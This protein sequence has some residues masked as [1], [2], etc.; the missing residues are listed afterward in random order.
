MPLINND[1]VYERRNYYS[2]YHTYNYNNKFKTFL[3]KN[4]EKKYND[5]GMLGN[6]FEYT[7]RSK[8]IK[9]VDPYHSDENDIKIDVIYVNMEYNQEFT[10]LISNI[11]D[12]D[13]CKNTFYTYD[14]K[15]DKPDT[16]IDKYCWYDNKC[17]INMCNFNGII[18]KE[19]NMKFTSSYLGTIYRYHKYIDRGYKINDISSIITGYN[20]TKEVLEIFLQGLEYTISNP[21]KYQFTHSLS[22]YDNDY[23]NYI[24]NNLKSKYHCKS[25]YN[26]HISKEHGLI[27]GKDF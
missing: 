21:L 19:I 24:I 16:K 11:S 12:F 27:Y 22:K 7:R 25:Y 8:Y 23:Y 1:I 3:E 18:N 4:F 6:D 14:N 20:K 5:V 2:G 15:E 26:K 13:I 9:R 17:K 10:E